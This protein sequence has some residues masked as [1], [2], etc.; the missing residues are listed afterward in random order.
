M[1][2]PA[3]PLLYEVA[4][5]PWLARLSG[6]Y[7]RRV[8]LGDV[9][10]EELEA[11]AQRGFD[12]LWTMGVWRTG[13]EAA[14]IARE[15]PWLRHRWREAFPDGSPPEIVASPYAIAEYRVDD[16][17]G[18]DAGLERLREQLVRAGLGLILDVVPHDT[19]TDAPWVRD[20]PDWYV[21]GSAAQRAADPAGYVETPTPG[22]SRWIAHGRD[23]N[24]PPWSDTVAL[25]FRNPAVHE[26]MTRVLRTLAGRCD[27]V[28]ADMAMLVLDDVFRRTWEGR[29]LPPGGYGA[30]GE[31]WAGAIAAVRREQPGFLF[32]AE[33]YWDLGWQLQQLGFD[34]TYDKTFHDRLVAGD[35]AALAAHL[36]A[37]EGF[38]RRSVRFL[39]NHDEPRAADVL[40]PAR[41]RA[42]AVLAASVP[43][44]FLVHDGQLEGARF[45]APVQ[46]ARR[47]EEPADTDLQAFYTRLLDVLRDSGLRR[48]VSIALEPAQAWPGNATHGAFV[49]R[50][51]TRPGDALHVAIVNL[52]AT[53]GQCRVAIPEPGP[54]GR[55]GRVGRTVVLEDLLG[56]ARYERP[57]DEL[58]APGL[59]VDLEAGAYHLFQLDG[60]LG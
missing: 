42:G 16:E 56:H 43:G 25:D 17:L 12:Y 28:R 20:H 15:Q 4:T 21:S 48:G 33:A 32:I 54:A 44:M 55:P 2:R 24:F 13:D 47:S 50:L 1:S 36:R 18:G 30:T 9:P 27:G 10:F 11:L 23:P 26:A 8:T 35:G 3:A 29:S 22:A 60:R 38:Q 41:H 40:P 46:F 34:F 52:G 45:R 59:Y 37:D 49:A 39:E 14:R 19:A 58:M 7:G 5:R 57:R 51:W 6:R 53:R 31:F